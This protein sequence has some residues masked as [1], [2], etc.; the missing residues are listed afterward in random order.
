MITE[1]SISRYFELVPVTRAQGP[2]S[3]ELLSRSIQDAQLHHVDA[4]FS[5]GFT[6]AGVST[7]IETIYLDLLAR[8]HNALVEKHNYELHM[9]LTR[10][11][12][13]IPLKYGSL[14]DVSTGTEKTRNFPL[15][16]AYRIGHGLIDLVIEWRT[17]TGCGQPAILIVENFSGAGHL[18]RRFFLDL[19]RRA[20]L[21]A[22][23]A[24]IV[25]T[26]DS[27]I[28]FSRD[29]SNLSAVSVSI[30]SSL[31]GA[32]SEP[33]G[34]FAS[35][36]E[37][38]QCLKGLTTL[39]AIEL[40]ANR[41]LAY[42]KSRGE[43]FR[44]AQTALLA[45]QACNHF[46]YYYE[47]SSFAGAVLSEFDRLTAGSEENRWN[48]A[49][50]VYH[51]LVVAGAVHEARNVI[52]HVA[53]PLLTKSALRA[54]MEYVLGIIDLR[55]QVPPDIAGAE[56]HLNAGVELIR[57]CEGE[58]DQ[59]EYAF[60][61]VFIENGLAFLRARQGRRHEAIQLCQDGYELLTRELGAEKHK[62]HRSV[63]QYNT[64]QVYNMMGDS[65]AALRHY[66]YA[67]QMDPNYSEYYNEV[68]NIYQRLGQFD[69]ALRFYDDAIRLSA[70]Y[71]EVYF[72]RAI[73]LARSN[74]WQNALENCTYSLE[75]KPDQPDAHLL[76]AEIL[77]QLGDF[78]EA[79]ISYDDAI[80]L[81]GNLVAARVNKAVLLF[82]QGNFKQALT[83]MNAVIALQPGEASHYDNRAAIYTELGRPDLDQQD[84]RKADSL[85]AMG[86]VEAVQAA[87]S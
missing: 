82:T 23:L 35:D 86:D 44:H 51:S 6:W 46:G 50:N 85:R 38:E 12:D 42:Y 81:D 80:A 32:T 69:Q 40:N 4:G 21:K 26:E 65:E 27:S 67:I 2:A 43:S 52:E 45:L 74:D 58:I 57:S 47:A 87:A 37:A 78:G 5:H 22:N 54:K 61:K 83:E 33:L 41:L 24:V 25:A 18:A 79:F 72:N 55:H 3:R 62:L 1:K 31:R 11:R 53:K 70:P 63:L 19:A 49:G 13:R 84:R 71:P 17:I 59:H 56:Q 8:G 9:V 29:E 60:L 39:E 77:E 76:R 36:E 64:A 7:F 73:C 20:S 68:G 10:Y 15:D 66:D 34:M 16:R 75:L 14:T 30:P 28:Q 48:Y